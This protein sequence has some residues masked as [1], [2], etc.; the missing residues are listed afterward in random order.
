VDRYDREPIWMVCCAFSWGAFLATSASLLGNT[1]AAWILYHLLGPEQA[2]LLVAPFVAPLVE[3]PFKALVLFGLLGSRRFDGGPDGFVYGAAAGFGFAATENLLYFWGAAE[4][5]SAGAGNGFLIWSGT[6]FART[7]FSAFLHASASGIIGASLGIGKFRWLPTR[8]A[9]GMLGLACALSAHATW[10]GLLTLGQSVESW[11][12]ALVVLDFLLLPAGV[13]LLALV[14]GLLLARERGVIERELAEEAKAG[15]IPMEYAKHIA[16]LRGRLLQRVSPVGV[17]E[18]T[19]VR[20][21]TD[22]ALRKAQA[23]QSN[24]A[25]KQFLTAEVERLRG[26]LLSLSRPSSAK[27]GTS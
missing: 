23:S 2:D 12:A 14:F 26:E 22:L 1:S 3:E 9:I 5:A 20:A 21:A 4:S 17:P 7:F 10:N 16:T 27:I 25:R 19:Y 11:G 13:V 8:V 15:Y 6:V 18:Q 24:G